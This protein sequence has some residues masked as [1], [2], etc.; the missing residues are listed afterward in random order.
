MID[1]K[2]LLFVCFLGYSPRFIIPHSAVKLM[3]IAKYGTNYK[4]N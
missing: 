1:F 3:R 2:I 4:K